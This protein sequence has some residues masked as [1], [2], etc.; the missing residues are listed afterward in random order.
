MIPHRQ[1][2]HTLTKLDYDTGPLMTHHERSRRLP[3]STLDVQVGVAHPRGS[4]SNPDLTSLGRIERD[5]FIAEFL[6]WV[7]KDDCLH[8]CSYFR[9]FSNGIL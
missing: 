1:R 8:E 3:L 6:I 2:R 4:D 9:P 5:I 7:A